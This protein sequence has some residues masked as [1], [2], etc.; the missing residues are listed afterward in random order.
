MDPI[1]MKKTK[2]PPNCHILFDEFHSTLF[3]DEIFD[4]F[5]TLNRAKSFTGTSGSPLSKTHISILQD[6]IP[7]GLAITFPD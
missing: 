7:E 4:I 2:L 1:M 3:N 6:T 5:P